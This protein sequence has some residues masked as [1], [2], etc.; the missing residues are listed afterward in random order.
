MG[1]AGLPNVLRPYS[2]PPPPPPPL[3]WS[4]PPRPYY[5]YPSIPSR[6]LGFPP[7]SI[8]LPGPRT[9]SLSPT[10]ASPPPTPSSVPPP[11][12]PFG[13]PCLPSQYLLRPPPPNPPV[14]PGVAK[15]IEPIGGPKG[16][17]PGLEHSLLP[18]CPIGSTERPL[19]LLAPCGLW[20][21]G[22]VKITKFRYH[23]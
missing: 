7:P 5:S 15:R 23:T 6:S 14:V 16:P 10:L 19:R 9:S 12:Q 20:P 8:Q 2:H 3:S 17:S 13:Q 22:S 1:R 18:L 4:H 21:L 11:L